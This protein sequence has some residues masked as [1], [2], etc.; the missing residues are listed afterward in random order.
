M[1][2]HWDFYGADSAKTAEHFYKHL[3]QFL[4]SASMSASGFG[5]F[6]ADGAH[7]C[8][9]IDVDS[10]EHSAL[11]IKRLRP[12]RTLSREEHAM[13]TAQLAPSGQELP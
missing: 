7:T 1:F 9:W 10:N 5:Y 11:I 6:S 4:E 13:L 12:Q 2:H 3:E 8:I